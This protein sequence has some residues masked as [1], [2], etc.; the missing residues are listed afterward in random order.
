VTDEQ[1][2]EAIDVARMRKPE[3]DPIPIAYLA[4]IVRE[5]VDRPVDAGGSRE[6][7]WSR[8]WPDEPAEVSP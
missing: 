2:R 8:I 3:P 7:D 1:L 4:P 5:L 6:R